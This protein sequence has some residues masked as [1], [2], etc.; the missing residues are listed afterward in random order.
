MARGRFRQALRWDIQKHNSYK[1]S[2]LD[3]VEYAQFK[4]LNL[5]GLNIAY[6]G[7]LASTKV[8]L[9]IGRSNTQKNSVPLQELLNRLIFDGY[10]LVWP[11]SRRQATEALL[12][13]ESMR[14]V[15][16]LNQ[17]FG[18]N[19]STIK[20]LIRRT[21]KGILLLAHPSR[22]D[23]SIHWLI[24]NPMDDQAL[25][26]RRAIQEIGR[27]KPIIIMS[28]SAG[29]V[30]AL[31]LE[32]EQNLA[33]IICFGYPFKHPDKEE[34]S[35]R[36]S[37]LSNLQKPMLIIQGITDEYGGPEVQSKYALS[38]N[39]EFEFVEANHE[40]EHLSTND[41]IR[42]TSRIKSFLDQQET[43]TAK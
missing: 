32:T 4:F 39:I 11:K 37:H 34:E 42:V 6:L 26:T 7:S 21:L 13:K 27:N 14:A 15:S 22:L 5:K 25:I 41:W 12:S 40:Y 35:Y 1:P 16:W 43:K 8:I 10:L 36:T 2:K 17:I 18:Q 29:G 31:G 19:E 20:V 33:G 28:H 9:F 38:S 3:R 23:Y 24:F 30:T